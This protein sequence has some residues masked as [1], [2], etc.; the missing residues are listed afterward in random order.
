M[1]LVFYYTLNNVNYVESDLRLNGT[2]G[3]NIEYNNFCNQFLQC[4]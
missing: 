2:L 4:N 3:C 1:Y